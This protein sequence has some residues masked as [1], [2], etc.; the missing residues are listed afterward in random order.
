[1]S[2]VGGFSVDLEGRRAYL[3][4]TAEKGIAWLRLVARG[5]A[6]HGSQVSEDNAVT[7]LADAV[8]RIGGHTW[9]LEITPTVRRLL[10]GIEEIIGRP[11]PADDPDELVRVLG[12]TAR[13]VGATLRNTSNPTRL[14]AGYKENVIPGDASAVIDCRYLPGQEEHLLAT[15]RELAGEGIEIE[16]IQSAP[17][18]EVPFEGAL[19]DRM[20]AALLAEDPGAAVLPYSLSGGTDNKAFSLLGI[21][22]YGFAPLRLPAGT[23]FAGMFHGVDERVPLDS[24]RFGAR[25]LRRFLG[26]A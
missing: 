23:D 22:G 14:D 19:V 20:T 9:P 26:T 15:I 11:L 12:T 25:T 10:A 3:V 7:K 24:L 6:Q 1:V 5:R 4:Q 18:L 13:F 16:A 2:E 8:S 17:A 21:T